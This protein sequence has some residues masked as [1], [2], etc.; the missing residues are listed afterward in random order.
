MA[1]NSGIYLLLPEKQDELHRLMEVS[2]KASEDPSVLR[3]KRRINSV[4]EDFE[5]FADEIDEADSVKHINSLQV[6]SQIIFKTSQKVF[7]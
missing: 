6:W 4:D 7:H 3:E 5:L 2:G 1:S